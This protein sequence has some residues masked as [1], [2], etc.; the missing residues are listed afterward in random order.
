MIETIKKVWQA[1]VA[2]VFFILLTGWWSV[3]QFIIGNQNIRY[4]GFFDFGEFYGYMALWG[5]LCGMVIAKKWGG[6]QSVIGKAVYM[7]SF[8]LLAQEFGQLAYAWYN[9][10]Y[11][12]PGPYPSIGD[13]GFFGSI[14]FYLAGIIFLANAAGVK[15]TLQLFAQK[16]QAAIIPLGMLALAYILFLQGYTF[17]WTNPVKIFLDFGYPFGQA[18]YVSLALLTFLFTKNVLGGIMKNKV[19]FIL[20]ALFMQFLC[21]YTFLY[22]SSKG[23]WS[24]GG[25]NDY[26]YFVSYFLMTFGLLQFKT[27]YDRLRST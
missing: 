13:I 11:K 14:L 12:T 25:I 10:I 3:N 7:F 1:K 18:L 26:M 6:F 17:D 8:G 19:L 22:Q 23:T 24:V 2:V 5:A 21:D 27:I 4:D 15:I 9:D 16:I 20:V